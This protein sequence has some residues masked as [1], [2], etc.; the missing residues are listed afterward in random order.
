MNSGPYG[1]NAR[2]VLSQAGRLPRS[3]S[4]F[5]F[6]TT[7]QTGCRTRFRRDLK[8][9]KRLCALNKV[10]SWSFLLLPITL[11]CNLHQG[12]VH[13]VV[14]FLLNS[15]T[16][17]PASWFLSLATI[18]LA[19]YLGVFVGGIVNVTFGNAAE[20]IISL[21]ALGKGMVGIV[22]SALL[23]A[24]VCD[25][26][27][28]LGCSFL[29]G[30]F[31]SSASF[32]ADSAK[33]YSSLL[34]L[35]CVSLCLP[36]AF[37]H[38]VRSKDIKEETTAAF[39][40]LSVSR[41]TSIILMVVYVAY[42]IYQSYSMR[43]NHGQGR[44]GSLKDPESRTEEVQSLLGA[45]R[46]AGVQEHPTAQ[47][48]TPPNKTNDT[49][50]RVDE[51]K[52]EESDD[53]DKSA[54]S[55]SLGSSV[56]MLALMSALVACASDVLLSVT[57]DLSRQ[58][59]FH[60][61]FTAFIILPLIATAAQT[62]TA[63]TVAMR[64]K[65]NLA[66]EVSLGSAIQVALFLLPFV[67]IIGWMIHQPMTLDFCIFE[68]VVL[69]LCVLLSNVVVMQ[70]RSNWFFGFLLLS[71]FLVVSV[72][73]FL[74]PRYNID[75]ADLIKGELKLKAVEESMPPG[76]QNSSRLTHARGSGAGSLRLF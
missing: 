36:T 8:V 15:L 48:W 53:M 9:L 74:F 1:S 37:F 51:V 3:D 59:G 75:D 5:S 27:L 70:G 45:D 46:T 65:M 57:R 4:T 54:R 68:V 28:V 49:H 11:Y 24:V 58:L 6:S 67:T 19:F 71:C 21:V 30:G 69:I 25:L 41:A 43:Q 60:H 7:E 72:A 64:G 34:V 40:I 31:K 63:V 42:L 20:M 50:D 13:N 22:Q 2:G 18:D 17:I 23:G 33:L 32:R 29:A 16:I 62:V 76:P 56:M 38:S 10:F 55:L 52:E 47:I 73:Y 44:N 61:S 12:G 35:V 66:V 14:L 39:D 26:L